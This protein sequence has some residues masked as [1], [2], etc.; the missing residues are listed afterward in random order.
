MPAPAPGARCDGT[1]RKRLQ[2]EINAGSRHLPARAPRSFAAPGSIPSAV[3]VGK[4]HLKECI[5]LPPKRTIR[6]FV[7]GAL[8]HTKD[9]E[10]NA[11]RTNRRR[12]RNFSFRSV[13]TALMADRSSEA[14][15]A[16]QKI[17]T[18]Q[19]R[20]VVLYSAGQPRCFPDCT[21]LL[22]TWLENA[23]GRP[24]FELR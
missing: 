9:H 2:T 20:Y 13:R 1:C 12:F 7:G 3:V 21:S 8:L 14:C 24:S 10:M 16:I 18:T 4:E 17:Y 5:R 22:H 23:L 19:S 15:D 6:Y 11:A